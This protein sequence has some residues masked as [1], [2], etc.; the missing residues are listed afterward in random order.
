M[1]GTPGYRPLLGADREGAEVQRVFQ[2]ADVP[3]MY[4]LWWL[5]C[6]TAAKVMET[7]AERG[8]NRAWLAFLSACSTAEVAVSALASEGI[9]LASAFQLA[10]FPHV[11]GSLWPVDD[12]VC[13]DVAGKFYRELLVSEGANA[14][15]DGRVARALRE[16]VVGVRKEHPDTPGLWAPFAHFGA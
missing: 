4:A 13:V 3:G 6:P 14:G 1:P 5:R 12:D 8:K 7:E 15:N 2:D 10:G 9:H 11:V 16:A